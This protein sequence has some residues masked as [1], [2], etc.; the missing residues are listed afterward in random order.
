MIELVVN[1][2]GCLMLIGHY[3]P[4]L[5][6]K[7]RRPALPLWALFIG[8]EVLDYLWS[9]FVIVGLE[10]L[11]IVP[12]INA[13]NALDLYDMPWSHSLVATVWWSLF[14]A[15]V[16]FV[17]QRGTSSRGWLAGSM[18]LA[19]ASHFVLDLVVHVDDL[20]LA[21]GASLRVG[22]G[23]WN[24][25]LLALV[26]EVGLVVGAAWALTVSQGWQAKRSWWLLALG[27]SVFCA[28]SFFIPTPSRP[29]EMALS[30]LALYI[31]LPLAAWKVESPS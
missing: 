31:V 5:L 7:M 10:H 2:L 18:A 26:I 19:V 24:H 30:G 20:P 1:I 22:L 15:V 16:V 13:S 8:V 11:R 6:L 3:A 14:A 9:I 23:A 12:G 17:W 27:M 21:S 4:A 29:V 25:K 28:A